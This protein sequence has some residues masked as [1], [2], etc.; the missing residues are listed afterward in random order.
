MPNVV[1]TLTVGRFHEQQPMHN[2]RTPAQ[3]RTALELTKRPGFQYCVGNPFNDPHSELKPDC[4][5]TF[6]FLWMEDDQLHA[7]RITA[8][9]RISRHIVASG[10]VEDKPNERY[11]LLGCTK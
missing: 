9:G 4:R 3:Q 1:A 10:V 5:C 2:V 7:A 8:T 6:T 11:I